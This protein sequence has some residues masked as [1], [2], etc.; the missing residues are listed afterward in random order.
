M[1]KIL[2]LLVIAAGFT[3]CEGDQ[4][5]PGI[6]GAD[7]ANGAN[8]R[9]QSFNTTIN[10]S[11]PDYSQLVRYPESIDVFPGDMTL[12][13]IRFEQVPGNNG[14]QVDVYRLLPQTLYTDFGEFQYNYDFTNGDA[15]IF[16]TGPDSTDFNNLT[17]ADLDNQQFRIVI[18]PVELVSSSTVDVTDYQAVMELA[19]LSAADVIEIQN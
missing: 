16:L 2:L 11:A 19:D 12:V 18:L 5:P 4:G 3:A 9:A 13:Y 15:T 6:P 10:F 7:G 14:G 1:K 8:D 17:T